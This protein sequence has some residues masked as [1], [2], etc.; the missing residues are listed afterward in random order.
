MDEID[1]KFI[2]LYRDIGRAQGMQDSLL[3]IVFAKLYIE[4]ESMA[5]DAL[6]KDT[7]YSLASISNMVK[8]FGAIAGIEKSKKP[9]SKKIYLTVERDFTKIIRGQFEKKQNGMKMIKE[10]MPNMIK[11]FKS[12]VKND[13]DKK[14]LKILEDYYKQISFVEDL[15]S[16]VSKKL[17]M[18]K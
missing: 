2:K 6:A 12:K 9:G 1:E 8:T 17:Y 15:L 10:K 16:E 11:E 5:M 3:L 13:K 14:K 18:D 4:P 7:G